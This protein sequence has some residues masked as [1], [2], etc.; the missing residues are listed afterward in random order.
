[1]RR[2]LMVVKGIALPEIQLM[3]H[4][5]NIQ[6]TNSVQMPGIALHEPVSFGERIELLNGAFL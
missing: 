2:I 5:H 3:L 1:M 6:V 4:R